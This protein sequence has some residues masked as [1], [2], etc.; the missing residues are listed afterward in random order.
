MMTN[1]GGLSGMAPED[2]FALGIKKGLELVK[3]L[4]RGGDSELAHVNPEEKAMLREAGGSGTVNPATGLPEFFGGRAGGVGKEGVGGG[5]DGPGRESGRGSAGG[6]NK[7]GGRAGAVGKSGVGGGFDGP[8][9][10]RAGGVGS[11]GV[12][13]GFDG[14]VSSNPSS[15]GGSADPGTSTGGT[16]ATGGGRAGGVGDSDA[17]GGFTDPRDFGQKVADAIGAAL[18]GPSFGRPTYN[19][20]GFL[21][22]AAGL[23]PGIGWG[24]GLTRALQSLGIEGTPK[25]EGELGTDAYSGDDGRILS[26]GRQQQQGPAPQSTP[27]FAWTRP[28]SAPEAPGG[29]GFDAG[30]TP[31]QQRAAIAT[32]GTNADAG[33]YR[34]PAIVDFYRNLATYSLT[35]PGGAVAEGAS[36]LP[37]EMQFLTQLGAQPG[38]STESFL[39]ALAG[40]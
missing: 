40:L 33:I 23:A 28:G 36:P 27:Q 3:D 37:I 38:D 25:Q 2:A 17:G 24:M 26:P 18:G 10:G 16:G 15:Q 21:G 4:G 32:G 14:G 8:G 31:L 34:D 13:G 35:Q 22:V 29:L 19:D 12:G 30:M 6:G 9:G 7:G 20:P 1:S 11:A 39:T 5:F